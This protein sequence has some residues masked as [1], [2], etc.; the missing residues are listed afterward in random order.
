M[1]VLNCRYFGF[2]CNYE[3]DGD[4]KKITDEF[5]NH[6]AKEHEI[7]YPKKILMQPILRK[8]L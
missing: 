3:I 1:S 7:D 4:I 5:Q 2:E 8:R 6:I